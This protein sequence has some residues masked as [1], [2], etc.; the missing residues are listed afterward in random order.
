MISF[1]DVDLH[2]GMRMGKN[3]LG[4]AAGEVLAQLPHEFAYL[5]EGG[6]GLREALFYPIKPLIKA[7]VEFLAQPVPLFSCTNLG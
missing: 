6:C 2:T 3:R 1:R 5:C 4:E 7:R